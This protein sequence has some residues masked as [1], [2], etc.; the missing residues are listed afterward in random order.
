MWIANNPRR[1]GGASRLCVAALVLLLPALPPPPAAADPGRQLLRLTFLGDIMGHDVNLRMED[2]SDIY[3]GVED[4]FR[5]DDLTVA[6]LEFPVEPTLPVSG[7]PLFNANRGYLDAALDAGVDAFS[8]ANNHAFD[9]REEGIFQTLRTAVSAKGAAAR[10]VAFSGIRGNPRQPFAPETIAVKGM[11]VGFIAATQFLNDPAGRPYV[12]VVDCTDEAAVQG[13]LS[14]VRRESARY[15]LFVVSYH[16]DNEYAGDPGPAK[17]SFFRRLLENGAHIV[18][19]HHPHVVQGWELAR[20]DGGDR[21]ILYS[22]GNF[23]SG[24]TWRLDPSEPAA[25]IPQRGESYLL[26]ARVLLT[27]GT[28]S[29][30]HAEAIPIA[31]YRNAR[32]EMVVGKLKELADGTV[33]LPKAWTSYYAGRLALM[34]KSVT[35]WRGARP[36]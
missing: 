5:A 18:C 36:R 8:L 23:I 12:N 14:L 31:N 1:G 26:A 30:L 4:V 2:Y 15:D 32:G 17:I 16:G 29:V 6:N 35:S 24:M 28:V 34:E 20:V 10:Q 27:G 9:Q 13:F 21:L 7:F 3:R 19:G 25:G 33:P 11:R 22:M